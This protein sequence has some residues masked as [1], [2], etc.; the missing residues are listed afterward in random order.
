[1]SVLRLDADHE[2]LAL[3][4]TYVTITA[5][6]EDQPA[7]TTNFTAKPGSVVD[8]VVDLDAVDVTAV[9]ERCSRRAS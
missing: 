9:A 2:L 4:A 6:G 5:F 8:V 3:G 7:S 1:V